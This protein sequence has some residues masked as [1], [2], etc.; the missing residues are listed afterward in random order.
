M[1][2]YA[3]AQPVIYLLIIAVIAGVIAHVD[4][5]FG[6]IIFEAGG[7]AFANA[8]ILITLLY[9]IAEIVLRQRGTAYSGILADAAV[10]IGTGAERGV[11]IVMLV[12]NIIA[13]M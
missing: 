9:A 6:A 8:M 5:A 2:H 10:P 3:A 12:G 1:R 13:V 7:A 11:D 4:I